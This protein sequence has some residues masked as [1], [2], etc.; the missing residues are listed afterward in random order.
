[1][2]RKAPENVIELLEAGVIVANGDQSTLTIPFPLS[3][4]D[5][6]SLNDALEG[7]GGKWNG[8]AKKHLFPYDPTPLIEEILITRELPDK[9][10]TAFFPTPRPLV[11]DALG[12]IDMDYFKYCTS[13]GRI[14]EKKCRALEPSAGIGGIA[15]VI[16]EQATDPEQL[17]LVCVEILPENQKI[18][19]AKGHNVIKGSFLDFS[20]PE[21]E[22]ELFDFIVM[23]PPFSVKGDALAYMTHIY[24][25]F[26]MLAPNGEMVAIIPTGWA[27]NKG[28]R[29]D[30]FRDFVGEHIGTGRYEVF[31]KGAFKSSGTMVETV[32]IQLSKSAWKQNSY[33][34]QVNYHVWSF[35]MGFTN[36]PKHVDRLCKYVKEQTEQGA[37]TVTQEMAQNI[38]HIV[39][40]FIEYNQNK[41]QFIFYPSAYKG[42][43]LNAALEYADIYIEGDADFEALTGLQRTPYNTDHAP[44]KDEVVDAHAE[45]VKEY[46]EE[47]GEILGDDNLRFKEL[48]VTSN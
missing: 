25:A 46:R 35:A 44:E 8:R 27:K 48:I 16:R 39:E 31:E 10:P 23:N 45:W 18:L 2:A 1:M 13:N 15:D 7:I 38:L 19:E 37:D 36:S 14:S 6:L 21:T 24:H 40:E 11:K 33:S 5:Y 17:D 12:L 9:N 41:D 26:E 4:K 43:Y 20:I 30:A 47:I 28:K 32:A 3:R 29:F 34:G 22:E 42:D